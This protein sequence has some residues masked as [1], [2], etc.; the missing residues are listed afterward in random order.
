M[1]NHAT[2]LDRVLVGMGLAFILDC[3]PSQIPSGVVLKRVQDLSIVNELDLI[4]HVDDKSPALAQFV[5]MIS[6]KC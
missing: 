1:D 6:G 4:W 2:A 5:G 3:K